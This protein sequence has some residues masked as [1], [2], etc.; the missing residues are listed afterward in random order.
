MTKPN[1]HFRSAKSWQEAA[2]LVGFEPEIPADTADFSLQSLAVFVRDHRQR[3]V[4]PQ[5]RSL[6]AHYGGFVLTQQLCGEDEARCLTLEVP[7]G[8]APVKTSVAGH[9]AR[10]YE[11]GPEPEPGDIDPRSPAVVAWHDAGRFLLIAS[12]ELPAQSLVAIA[13]SIYR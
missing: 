1:P 2:D 7:Y 9:E 4:P 6:E 12:D 8:R 13:Q 3:E 5:Q 11:L 10:L